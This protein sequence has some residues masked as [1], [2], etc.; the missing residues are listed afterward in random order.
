MIILLQN[1]TTQ[2][3]WLFLQNLSAKCNKAILFKSATG[4]HYKVRQA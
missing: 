4:C 1:V 2:F 3:Y